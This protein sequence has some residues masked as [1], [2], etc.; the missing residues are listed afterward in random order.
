VSD[1]VRLETADGVAVVTVDNPPVNT[2]ADAVLEQLGNV[3]SELAA[4]AG[5]RAVVLTGAGDKAFMAGADLAEFQRLLDGEGSIEDHV[6]TSHRALGLL[7]A[8]PQ[9]VVAAVQASAMGGGLE[10]ALVCDLIVAD[11]EARL[12][13][14]EVRLGLMPG[15]GG[16][17]RLPA[18]IGVGPAR[19][20]LLL[21]RAVTAE[22]G[23][24]LGLV[25]RVSAPGAAV[26]EA[27]ELATRLAAL[28]ARAVT[29]IKRVLA[30]DQAHALDRERTTFLQLF[31]TDDVR[32]GVAAFVEKRPPSF[33]HG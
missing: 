26:A 10:V 30:A 24:R 19:E 23:H 4:N 22:E 20:L 3:A 18:R 7:E 25:N 8:I 27:V 29:S 1:A 2:L 28:P 12:G 9:P 32:E 16:T 31:H 13:L 11:P 17:A 14:P 5:V 6:D 33:T 15:A 21:G